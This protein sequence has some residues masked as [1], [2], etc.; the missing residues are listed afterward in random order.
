MTKYREIF[1]LKSL[2]FG[3]R[4]IAHSCGVSRNTVAKVIKRVAEIK[5]SWTLDYDITDSTLEKTLFFKTKSA[6]NKWMLA[7]DYIRRESLR[8]DVNKKLL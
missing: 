1:R 5:L 4:N 2:G 7:C 3:E 8:N 6:T